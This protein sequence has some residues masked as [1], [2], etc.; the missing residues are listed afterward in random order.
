M[1]V[2]D[3]FILGIFNYCDR[4]CETCSLTSR[5][6][7]FANAAKYDAMADEGLQAL[8]SAPTH[9]SDVRETRGWLEEALSEIAEHPIE[10][11]PEPAPL[12]TKHEQTVTRASDYCERVWV[13]F[14]SRDARAFPDLNDPYAVIN[15][16]APL[17]ASKVRRAIDG[18]AEDDG[19]RDFPPDFAGSAK[20]ALIGADRSM[21]AWNDLVTIGRIAADDARPFLEELARLRSELEALIPDARKF[22]R[23]GFDE[24]DELSRLEAVDWS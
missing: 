22:V 11:L 12:S 13:W 3:G 1:E 9:Q 15:W 16:F 10:A 17:V 6:Q 5:C 8:I 19:C 4:W 21:T 24:P 23:P 2:Q 18:L 14:K 20:V 7:V